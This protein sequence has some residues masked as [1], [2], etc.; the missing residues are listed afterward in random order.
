MIK[1]IFLLF[2]L[3]Y[4]LA[5]IACSQNN[6]KHLKLKQALPIDWIEPVEPSGLAKF[7]DVLFTISDD[8]DIIFKINFEE[9]RV[10]LEPHIVLGLPKPTNVKKYDFEGITVDYQGNFYLVSESTFRIL[11]VSPD[12]QEM[13][14]ITPS[15]EYFGREKGLFKYS[16][17]NFEGLTFIDDHQFILCA[18]REPRGFIQVNTE[19]IPDEIYVT[20]NNKSSRQ[21]PKK[22]PVDYTGLHFTGNS[23]F[24]LERGASTICE[25][26][27]ER[28]TVLEKSVWSYAKIETSKALKYKKMKYGRGE[29][30]YIDEN[31]VYVILDNN[32]DKRKYDSSDRRPL[33]LIMERPR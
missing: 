7:N 29:G 9:D 24:V 8:H 23:L 32:G 4:A 31:N 25:I 27:V 26:V 13:D 21:W 12:G 19:K 10:V 16:N 18:E 15:L 5:S 28:D 3:F 14:W 6:V 22:R 30:L 2:W 11:K 20:V 1:Y 33:L 17:A